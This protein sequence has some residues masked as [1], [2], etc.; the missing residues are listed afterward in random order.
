MP[1]A[2]RRWWSRTV[3]ERAQLDHFLRDH[4]TGD[5]RHFEPRLYDILYDLTSSIGHSGGEIDI[6]CGYR[7]SVDEREDIIASFIMAEIES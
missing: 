7:T 1:A 4:R 5:V 6:I 3:A 2:F